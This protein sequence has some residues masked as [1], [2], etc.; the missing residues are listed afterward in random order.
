MAPTINRMLKDSTTRHSKDSSTCH[1]EESRPGG[2]TRNLLFLRFRRQKQIPRFA[3]LALCVSLVLGLGI[4]PGHAQETDR[5][6]AVSRR[7]MCMCGC[8]QVLGECNHIGCP[9]RDPMI[10]DVDRKVASGISDDLI[11]QD[12][13]QEYG[14]KVLAEPP[15]RGFNWLAWLMPVFVTL[16]GFA[17]VR[18]VI[19]RWNHPV[20]VT[21]AGPA[22]SDEMLDR[23][24]RESELD[25]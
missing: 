11:V 13:I 24:R 14:E 22:P 1:S 7:V 12:F 6:K 17:V 25:D 8:G 16:A 3:R 4:L 5:A 21:S 20:A 23:V 15:A 18:A 10:K 2:T 19:V 9:S